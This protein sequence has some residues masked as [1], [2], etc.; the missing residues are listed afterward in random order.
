MLHGQDSIA[1]LDDPLASCV[2]PQR[3]A[4]ISRPLI[5]GSEPCSY[6][7]IASRQCA[8]RLANEGEKLKPK[9]TAART[10]LFFFLSILRIRKA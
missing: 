7:L 6:S 2:A 3:R 9:V 8:R 1:G 10:V 4:V 5:G